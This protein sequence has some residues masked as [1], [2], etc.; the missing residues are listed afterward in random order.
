MSERDEIR[1]AEELD[2]ENR[3]LDAIF[4][5]TISDALLIETGEQFPCLDDDE[6]I[7]EIVDVATGNVIS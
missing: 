6:L 4:S 5:D 2:A 1:K 3:V 7:E